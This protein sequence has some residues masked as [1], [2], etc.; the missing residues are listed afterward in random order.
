MA[1]RMQRATGWKEEG[2]Q[3][4]DFYAT[5]RWAIEA[6][7]DR[8]QF[9]GPVWECA[10]GDGA[11]SKVLEERGY[12]VQSSDIRTDGVYGQGGINFLWERR[13]VGSI[14][15]NPPFKLAQQFILHS[16]ECAKKV[17]IFGRIQLLE[18][19]ERYREIYKKYPPSRVYIF[20]GR[21][22]CLKEGKKVEAGLMCF[23]W[24]IFERGY[25]GKPTLDWIVPESKK[26]KPQK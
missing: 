25:K 24:F 15:T 8:E 22:S 6:L 7:L 14:I 1:T 23:A 4:D 21:C 9:E 5:P 19:L 20:S 12:S 26:E 18:G 2:R 17:A 11:I 3:K 13:E 16:L 10:S